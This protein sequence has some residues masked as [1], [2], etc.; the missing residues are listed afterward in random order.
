MKAG[1]QRGAEKTLGQGVCESIA[2]TN[3]TMFN[4]FSCIWQSFYGLHTPKNTYPVSD[5]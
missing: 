5:R 4:M 1:P 3:Q 2:Y